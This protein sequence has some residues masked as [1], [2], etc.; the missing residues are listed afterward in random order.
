MGGKLEK[1]GQLGVLES[2]KAAADIYSPVGGTVVEIN[3]DLADNPD[4]V[5]ADPYEKGDPFRGLDY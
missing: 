2:V 3:P 4:L 1:S 5:N